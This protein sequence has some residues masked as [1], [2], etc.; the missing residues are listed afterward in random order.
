MNKINLLEN[1]RKAILYVASEIAGMQDFYVPEGELVAYEIDVYYST[2][3]K[4]FTTLKKYESR[5]KDLVEITERVSQ[6]LIGV[7]L[8]RLKL[9]EEKRAKVKELFGYT[10][11]IED[12]VSAIFMS[13]PFISELKLISIFVEYIMFETFYTNTL[14]SLFTE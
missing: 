4:I 6:E 9:L 3:T 2:S 11:T 5:I 14:K 8:R 7:S 10:L 1:Q 13:N 12:I